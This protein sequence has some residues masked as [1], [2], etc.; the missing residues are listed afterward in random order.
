MLLG[1][2]TIFAFSTV[3]YTW[4]ERWS[5]L[6]SLY[7]TVV[8]LTTVGYG[9][10]APSSPLSRGFTIILILTGVGFILAFLNF[11]VARTVERRRSDLDD[12]PPS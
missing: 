7:F 1:I 9:D 4:V 3:F 10:F 2:L 6:D 8:T 5:V 11:L 12:G